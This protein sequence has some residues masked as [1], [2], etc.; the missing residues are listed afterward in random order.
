[1][2]RRVVQK[3]ECWMDSN[4]VVEEALNDIVR[5]LRNRGGIKVART[6]QENLESGTDY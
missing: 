4:P 2:A 1:V 3:E 6:V 5:R